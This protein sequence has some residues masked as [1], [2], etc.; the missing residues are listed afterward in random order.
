MYIHV[1]I[2]ASTVVI[3][4]LQCL[5]L[6]V[7]ISLLRCLREAQ[8]IAEQKGASSVHHTPTT[9]EDG[10]GKGAESEAGDDQ[11]SS[12]PVD[13]LGTF[14][15]RLEEFIKSMELLNQHVGTRLLRQQRSRTL[16]SGMRKMASCG[17][18]E[19]ESECCLFVMCKQGSRFV[20]CGI[21]MF[22]TCT[23]TCTC[24]HI[25]NY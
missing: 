13:H 18:T 7:R 21:Y 6:R 11:S 14:S 25:Q 15:E 9:G 5:W 24:M 19:R 10:R 1:A 20:L 23:C 4:N 12:N 8:L 3:L 22:T 2:R 16:V 17:T